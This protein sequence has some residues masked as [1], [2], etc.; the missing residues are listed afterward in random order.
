MPIDE[1]ATTLNV[2]RRALARAENLA[3]WM[4][5]QTPGP[6][7]SNADVARHALELGLAKLERNRKRSEG[8]DDA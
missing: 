1:S 8:G 6:S 4:S 7:W 5:E 3:E 2:S